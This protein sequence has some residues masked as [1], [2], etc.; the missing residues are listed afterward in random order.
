MLF[1][2]WD[3][4][5]YDATEGKVSSL[6]PATKK[7]IRELESDRPIVIDAF[8]SSEIP[9]QYAKTRYELINLL[10]EFRSEASKREPCHRSQLVRWHRTVQ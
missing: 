3:S 1:R 9:E 4:L 5:R 7:L 8:I 10:K 6:A 2:S